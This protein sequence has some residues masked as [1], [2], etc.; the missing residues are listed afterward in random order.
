MPRSFIDPKCSVDVTQPNLSATPKQTVPTGFSA[1]PPPGPAI[2]VTDTAMS[3]PVT[4]RAPSAIM[5]AHSSETA[6]C[7]WITSAE[8]PST[9]IL[10]S[11]EYETMPPS[12]T[13]EQPGMSP[14]RDA[15]IP[16]VQLSAVATVR[17]FLRRSSM[18][19][20]TI[21]S[22]ASSSEVLSANTYLPISVARIRSDIARHTFLH[23][24]K[25]S[26]LAVMRT[27]TSAS[28]A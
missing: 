2:P 23:S 5:A 8:T 27:L 10:T 24:S 22:D 9:F 15:I 17:E 13:S 26:A 28:Q 1:V 7:F 18:S 21:T 4:R 19:R 14:I 25:V 6:P 11:L 20:L 3:A 12:S 16:A